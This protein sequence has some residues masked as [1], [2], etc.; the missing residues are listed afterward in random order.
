MTVYKVHTYSPFHSGCSVF[1]QVV[2][3]NTMVPVNQ[4]SASRCVCGYQDI[5]R[6]DVAVEDMELIIRKLMGC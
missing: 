4:D 2:H 3:K 5:P 1:R 6:A